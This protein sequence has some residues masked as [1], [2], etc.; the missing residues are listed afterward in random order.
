MYVCSTCVCEY[1]PVLAP[2]SRTE[3]KTVLGK[4]LKRFEEAMEALLAFIANNSLLPGIGEDCEVIPGEFGAG[5]LALGPGGVGSLLAQCSHVRINRP[6]PR[7][8]EGL[9]RYFE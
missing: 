8:L 1:V 5:V 7:V 2:V 4:A 9:R 6:C 3:N